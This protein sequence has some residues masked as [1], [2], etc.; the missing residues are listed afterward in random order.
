MKSSKILS[1]A[2]GVRWLAY[3]LLLPACLLACSSEENGTMPGTPLSFTTLVYMMADNSMDSQVDYA[4]GQLKQGMKSKDVGNTVIYL[5]R[6]DA[7]PRLFRI[8]RQG[9]EIPLKDYPEENSAKA[10]TLVR[11]IGETKQLVPADHFGLVLWGHATG[12][13]PGGYSHDIMQVS[14]PSRQNLNTRYMG[15][16]GTPNE[17]TTSPLIEID[18]LAKLLPDH[19][20]DY[21]WFDACLMANVETFYQLRH[22]C[23]YLIGSPTVVL[24]EAQYDVSGIPYAKV[25]PFLFGGKDALV[26][27]CKTYYR[28]YEGKKY[29]NMRSATITLVDASKM[30]ALHQ[31]VNVLL[32][33]RLSGVE[34]M[35]TR[36]LQAYHRDNDPHVFFDLADMIHQSTNQAT[37]AFDKALSDAVLYKAA[38]NKFL[39]QLTLVPGHCCGLSVYVPLKQWNATKEYKYYFREMEWS[40]VYGAN[41][42]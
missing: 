24:A 36:T 28:H 11:V 9:E 5:D 12:W 16:D 3:L 39:D 20:A 23:Q 13:L 40:N 37:P 34:T 6:Q 7:S 35:D 19:V 14:V 33:N 18:A 17:A 22:K 29:S 2:H 8:S 25:L 31:N 10:E 1:L 15:L 38:T 4:V 32:K 42:P 27:A 41:T 30:D 26:Q 21:I